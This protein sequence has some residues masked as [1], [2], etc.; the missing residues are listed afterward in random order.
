MKGMLDCF[1]VSA[2]GVQANASID[3]NQIGSPAMESG[4]V[5]NSINT[6]NGCP[7]GQSYVLGTDKG[8]RAGRQASGGQRSSQR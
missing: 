8:D 3:S 2:S 4:N 7:E 6:L 1:S 5:H